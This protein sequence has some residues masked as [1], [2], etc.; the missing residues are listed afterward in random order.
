MISPRFAATVYPHGPL[1]ASSSDEVP[2]YFYNS[3]GSVIVLVRVTKK[4]YAVAIYTTY[5]P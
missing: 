5:Q 4:K 2:E 1:S 3:Q